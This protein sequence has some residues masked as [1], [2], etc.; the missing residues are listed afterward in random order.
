[1][2]GN[3][4]RKEQLAGPTRIAWKM[5]NFVSPGRLKFFF[6]FWLLAR[7]TP[8]LLQS[9]DTFCAIFKKGGRFEVFV[10]DEWVRPLLFLPLRFFLAMDACLI[11]RGKHTTKEKQREWGAFQLDRTVGLDWMVDL[12]S[13][14]LEAGRKK[15]HSIGEGVS[16]RTS[17]LEQEGISM[18]EGYMISAFMRV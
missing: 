6:F 5:N 1:M 12:G 7:T 11:I 16:W 3:S 8:C 14:M 18:E 17:A 4:C 2:S 10:M 13:R 9:S 15:G